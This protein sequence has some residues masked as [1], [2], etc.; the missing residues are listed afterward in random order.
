MPLLIGSALAL[1]V[2]AFARLTRMDRDRA[3]YSAVLITVATYYIL[4]AA[5]S[6][7]G[8]LILVESLLAT[9]FIA[10]AAIGFRGDF[11]IVAAALVAHGLLDALHGRLVN[12]PSVPVWWPAFCGAFDV[13]AGALLAWALARSAGR[14]EPSAA[15]R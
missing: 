4:F 15:H 6:A 8:T 14:A 2:Y 7:N 5:M 11:R 13:A 1:G 3:F 9:V 12:N 10:A